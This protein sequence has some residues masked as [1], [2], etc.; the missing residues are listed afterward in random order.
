MLRNVER[1][2]RVLPVTR[3]LAVVIVPFLVL[4]FVV[5]YPWPKDT[6]RLFAWTIKPTMTPMVLGAVYLGG[7]YFFVRATRATHWHTIKAGFPPVATFAALMGVATLLHWDKFNHHHLA[8]WLWVALYFTTPFLV[9][10]VWLANRRLEA[11][12]DSSELLV[13]L[14]IGRLIGIVGVAAAA[15]SATLFLA[16][17]RAVDYWPWLVTPLTARVMGAI[18]ALGIAAIG[19]FTERRWSCLKIMLQVEIFMLALILVAAVRAHAEFD[20]GRPL[21]WVFAVGFV[22]VF[23]GSLGL[24]ARMA[25][26][27]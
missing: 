26:R 13:S 19:G 21:T 20:T 1:D 9:L 6:D 22:G 11:P 27:Q 12:P 23:A 16:P 7:A 10:G 25:Q 5:L 17:Q 2:D 15:M 24:Y 8:F 18:F 3:G 14:A 4:A